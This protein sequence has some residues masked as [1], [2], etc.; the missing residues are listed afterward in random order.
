[1]SSIWVPRALAARAYVRLEM[2]NT[3]MSEGAPNRSKAPRSSRRLPTVVGD[4]V[5]GS[6]PGSCPR[7][8]G[9]A[10]AAA[11]RTASRTAG[12]SRAGG[13]R[14]GRMITVS[15]YAPVAY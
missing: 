11:A 1:M 15:G 2:A 4:I 14:D 5:P 8:G 13:D 3:S 12:G 6:C 9:T 7:A 10:I